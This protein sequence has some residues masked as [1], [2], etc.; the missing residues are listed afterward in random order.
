MDIS[1]PEYG[2][3][4]NFFIL[5]ALGRH[6]PITNP[7]KI[8]PTIDD[9]LLAIGPYSPDV[10]AFFL[11]TN[12]VYFGRNCAKPTIASMEKMLDANVN[13]KTLFL[14]NL[15]PISRNSC[16]HSNIFLGPVSSSTFC[17]PR[18][19]FVRAPF[20]GGIVGGNR[21]INGDTQITIGATIANPIHH[22]PTQRGCSSLMPVLKHDLVAPKNFNGCY[23]C[24]LPF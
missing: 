18:S 5:R 10:E 15:F 23:N 21:V 13:T 3:K 20:G 8:T 14:D 6:F 17:L 11:N 4:L 2:T 9:R 19:A 24:Y 22:A 7:A 16:H 1:A 12:S